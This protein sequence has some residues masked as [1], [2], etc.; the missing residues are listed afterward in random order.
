M[1]AIDPSPESHEAFPMRAHWLL[2]TLAV[3]TVL[4]GLA[5]HGSARAASDEVAVP[6]REVISSAATIKDEEIVAFGEKFMAEKEKLASEEFKKESAKIVEEIRKHE[7]E[8]RDYERRLRLYAQTHGYA[9]SGTTLNSL[10]EEDVVRV[11]VSILVPEIQLYQAIAATCRRRQEQCRK[12]AAELPALDSNGDNILSA[13]EYQFAAALQRSTGRILQSLDRNR[14]GKV[15]LAE[16]EVDS[17]VP[18][19]LAEA[20][21]KGLNFVMASDYRIKDFDLDGDG[22][23]S[24]SERKALTMAFVDAGMRYGED[25]KFYEKLVN[26]LTV[27]RDA[28]ATKFQNLKVRGEE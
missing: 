10:S 2:G 20:V 8:R 4:A 3:W 18:E 22:A 9:P 6:P 7:L 28:L 19:T 15:S 5:V 24:V 23:L 25:A 27:R 1:A 21:K 14:D 11:R 12:L 17:D 16:L 13:E 26:Q